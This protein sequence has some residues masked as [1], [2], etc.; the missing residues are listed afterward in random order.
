M[1]KLSIIVPIY[2]VEPYLRKCIDSLLSQDL[3]KDEYE[4]I[5]VDDG[6][7]DN[8]PTICD[9]Y[10]QTLHPSGGSRKGA[11]IKVIH[12]PNG[13]LSAAR[14]SGLKVAEG[15]YVQFV[16]SDD[17]LQPNVLRGLVEQM[18]HE[19]LD[20]LRFDYQ[21]VRITPTGDYEVFQPYKHPHQVDTRTDV[22]DG[23]AYLNERMGY[24]CYAVMFLIRR[25]MLLSN[26][27][28]FVEGILFEDTEWTP[29]ML[30]A[31]KRVNST[32]LVAYNYLT[33]NGSI[34]QMPTWQHTQKCIESFFIVNRTLKNLSSR[35]IQ[36]DWL[37]GCISDNYYSILNNAIRY[38]YDHFCH[39]VQRLKQDSA[40][41][42]Y[43]FRCNRNTRI[44]YFIINVSPKL[45]AF[46]MHS[47]IYKQ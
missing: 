34:T 10:A 37:R 3:P 5:L 21:N 20:V 45:Y 27:L 13:G 23:E 33:R 17:Y 16:D 12:Q 8:C 26:H 1:L 46:I 32:V 28:T 19:D 4:I 15:K 47:F 7:P 35:T 38:D 44:K 9:E 40:F 2:N 42:F 18:E 6:S 36:N 43:P 11:N 30:L 25:E 22:V 29:R 31:A 24:A 41:P 39:W 14:N